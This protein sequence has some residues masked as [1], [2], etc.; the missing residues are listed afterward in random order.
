MNKQEKLLHTVRACWAKWKKHDDEEGTPTTFCNLFVNDVC[1][2]YGYDGFNLMLANDIHRKLLVEASKA[3][4]LHN[5]EHV[6]RQELVEKKYEKKRSSSLIIASLPARGHGHVCILLPGDLVRSGK[7]NC[8][9][10]KCANIGGSNFWDRGVNYAFK[11][12]PL[13]FRYIGRTK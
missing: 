11:S 4:T 1:K 2:A 13:F 7:W 10:P 9:I 5:W 12:E 8:T 6:Y 3:D